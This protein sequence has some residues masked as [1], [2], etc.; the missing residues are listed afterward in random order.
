MTTETQ[1]L[2]TVTEVDL[3]DG[4]RS[5]DRPTIEVYG[6]F[7]EAEA[8]WRDAEHRCFGYAYQQ[9]DWLSRWYEEFGERSR[10]TPQIVLVRDASGMPLFLFPLGVASAQGARV[11]TWMGNEVNAHQAPL[12][13]ALAAAW[14]TD[15]RFALLW[16]A[17]QGAVQRHD[18]VHFWEQPARIG[19]YPNPMVRLEGTFFETGESHQANLSHHTGPSAKERWNTYHESV[20]SSRSRKDLARRL[21]RLKERGEVRFV[22]ATEPGEAL[23]ITELMMEQKSRRFIETRAP[24]VFARSDY[25]R[26]FSRV[27]TECLDSGL[28][29]IFALYC[30]DEIVATNWT[31]LADRWLTGLYSGYEE[32]DW[33]RLSVGHLLRNEMIEWCFEQGVAVIDFS[34]GDEPYKLAWCDE[35]T[36]LSEYFAARSVLGR[37][38]TMPRIAQRRVKRFAME[39][40]PVAHAARA[41]KRRARSLL[42]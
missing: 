15:A 39:L 30:G 8:A 1:I 17:V 31:L 21:R 5:S 24:D 19:P 37:T 23:R 36:A 25:Q 6:T 27:A 34:V 26:L 12:M 28:T 33:E 42:S 18:A 11:L 35:Q 7:A 32:G 16:S 22:V 20:M 2:T 38:Y 14:T 3:D 40:Q 29:R 4:G 9:Y 41:A 10:I 13:H